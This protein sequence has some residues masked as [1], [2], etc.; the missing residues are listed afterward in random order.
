MSRQDK[1]YRVYRGGRVKGRVPT[2]PKRERPTSRDGRKPLRLRYPG[3]GPKEKRVRLRKIGWRRGIV[4]REVGELRRVLPRGIGEI[5]VDGRA[6]GNAHGAQRRMLRPVRGE[7]GQ[8]REREKNEGHTSAH[9][10]AR[11]RKRMV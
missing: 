2:V 6:V 11:Y 8:G 10:Y 9:R 4:L 3:P 7:G 1:P 5:T